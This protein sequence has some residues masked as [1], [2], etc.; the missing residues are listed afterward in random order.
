[1]NILAILNSNISDQQATESLLQAAIEILPESLAAQILED[2]ADQSKS[3]GTF[4]IIGTFSGRVLGTPALVN[5]R[6]F[7]GSFATAG[8]EN[9]STL[10]YMGNIKPH[11]EHRIETRLK[12]R[13]IALPS[14]GRCFAVDDAIAALVFEYVDGLNSRITC[15]SVDM[16]NFYAYSTTKPCEIQHLVELTEERRRLNLKKML[17]VV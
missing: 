15:G 14:L 1:M 16:F 4:R 11:T 12:V 6:V 9:I 2:A 8:A 3:V 10:I 5:E 7:L 13:S 17:K